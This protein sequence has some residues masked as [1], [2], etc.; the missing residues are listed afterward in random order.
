MGTIA[1]AAAA[2]LTIVTMAASGL[3]V[4][5][6][7]AAPGTGPV[8]AGQE[9]P[10]GVFEGHSDIG[11]VDVPGSATY[12][13]QNQEYVIEGSGLNM[14]F[15]SDEGHLLWKRMRGDFILS[16]RVEFI[17]EGAAAHRKIGWMIRSTLDPDS[18]HVS[19]VVHGDGLTSAQY[20]T[21][22]G[23]QTL[24]NEI[25][26]KGPNQIQLERRGRSYIMSVAHFGE[27]YIRAQVGDFGLQDEVY[28][29]LFICAHRAGTLERARFSNVRIIIPPKNGFV[30]Y[31][32]HIGSRLEILD[33]ATKSRLV[34]DESP[35]DR[36]APNW[37][38]DGR[39]LIY[40]GDGRLYRFDLASGAST[41]ID[42]GSLTALNNDH[43]LSFDG[44]RL[45]VSSLFP[46][47]AGVSIIYTLPVGGGRPT[48]VTALGPSYLHGWSPDGRS[49]V[50][51]GLR[52]G[53][54]DIYK[55]SVRGGK[56]T[57]LTKAGGLDDGPEFTP[58]GR[59]IYFNSNRKGG[60]RIWRMRA[61]GKVQKPVTF[62]DLQ[63]WFPH[64]SPDGRSIVFLS[65]ER[66]VNPG[67]HPFDKQVYLRMMPV[68]GGE[69]RVIAYVFGGQGTINVPSWSP[70]GKRIA[71]FSYS[72]G[73]R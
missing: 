7:G 18:A 13:P 27:T 23:E 54:Y 15:A 2:V 33:I 55:I 41:V 26:V 63:D 73:I 12:N 17:G 64:V 68:E 43:V 21:A 1:L 62:D 11:P 70:D 40:N 5:A 67:D 57:R 53:N 20:R 65:Y 36:Q 35:K 69:A 58:D 24:E 29:G 16:A 28:A 10:L 14:W 59:F 3:C 31:H 32:D 34:L 61:N 39:A 38:K 49:L 52:K 44:K 8:Q 6:S 48:R 51:T 25:G 45:G 30:P 42:T 19:A 22:R 50:Y 47:E 72:D 4:A 60:M 71:F 37:T 66:D 56:E 9:N 46:N